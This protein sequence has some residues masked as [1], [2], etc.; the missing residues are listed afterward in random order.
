[1]NS[2]ATTIGAAFHGSIDRYQRAAALCRRGVRGDDDAVSS[3][4]V[5]A[6]EDGG[7]EM[8][9]GASRSTKETG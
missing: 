3:G 1:V 6:G 2:A 7:D 9:D 8:A 4:V 5:T